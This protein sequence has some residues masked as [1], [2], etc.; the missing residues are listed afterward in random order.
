MASNNTKGYIARIG[1]NIDG[2][3]QALKTVT[4]SMS[5]FKGMLSSLKTS[6]N[7]DPTNIEVIGTQFARCSEMSDVFVQTLEVMKGNYADFVKQLDSEDPSGQMTKNFINDFNNL[8][9]LVERYKSISGE[10]RPLITEQGSQGVQEF[11]DAVEKQND[12]LSEQKSRLERLIPEYDR[13]RSAVVGISEQQAEAENKLSDAHT[14]SSAVMEEY[15]KSDNAKRD[16]LVSKRSELVSKRDS[17]GTNATDLE[18]INAEIFSIDEALS[19]LSINEELDE[20]FTAIT[21]EITNLTAEQER[22]QAMFTDANTALAEFVNTNGDIDEIRASIERVDNQMAVLAQ[23]ADSVETINAW[24]KL[25]QELSGMDEATEETRKELERVNAA[26]EFDP[27]NP[28]LLAQKMSLLGKSTEDANEKLKALVAEQ[29]NMRN[30]L[31]IGEISQEEYNAYEQALM[32]CRTEIRTLTSEQQEL[33]DNTESMGMTWKDVF[34]ANIVA[35]FVHDGLQLAIDKTKELAAEAIEVGKSFDTAMSNTAGTFAITKDSETYA[36][37]KVYAQEVGATTKYTATE[38]AEALNYYALAGYSA[39]E[40]I[41]SL[42]ATLK[43]AQAGAMDFAKSTD[44]LTDAF[45][46]LGGITTLEDMVDQMTVTSQKSN[47][48]VEQLGEA[49]LTIGATARNLKGGTAE[50][51]TMLGILADNGLKGEEGGTKLRNAITALVKPTAD[52]KAVLEEL[53]VSLYDTDGKMRA[54]PDVLLEFNNA[55]SGFTQQQR[56]EA[57]ATVFNSRDLGAVNALLSTTKER[58]TELQ[59]EIERSSGAADALVD[60]QTNNLESA[61]KMVTSAKEALQYAV[62]DK[63]ADGLQDIALNGADALGRVTEML[64]DADISAHIERLTDSVNG[65]I[66]K[67]LT[68]LESDGLEAIIDTMS[69]TVDVVNWLVTNIDTLATVAKSAGAAFA[70][71]KLKDIASG[72]VTLAK[73][74][75]NLAQATFAAETAQTGLN[76]AQK[77]NIYLLIAS[78]VAALGVAIADFVDRTAEAKVA[79]ADYKNELEETYLAINEQRRMYEEEKLALEDNLNAVDKSTSKIKDRWRVLQGMV[80]EDGNIVTA[81]EEV[82]KILLELNTLM[83]SNIQLINGQVQGYKD[84]AGSMDDYIENLR[85]TKKLEYM[86]DAYVEALGTVDAEQSTANDYAHTYTEKYLT[87]KNFRQEYEYAYSQ[88][89][90]SDAWKT[91]EEKYKNEIDYD[92]KD[93]AS[94]LFMISRGDLG[95]SKKSVGSESYADYLD[96]LAQ[97][98]QNNMVAQQNTVDRLKETMEE[99][100]SASV[101]LANKQNEINEAFYE[102]SGTTPTTDTDTTTTDT[103]SYTEKLD[104][105]MQE[106]DDKLAIHAMSEDKYWTARRAKLQ[107]LRNDTSKEWWAYQDEVSSYFENDAKTALSEFKNGVDSE[108]LSLENMRDELDDDTKDDVWY[109]KE[110]EKIVKRLEG[111]EIYDAYYKKLLDAQQ[112][113]RDSNNK[114][115]QQEIDDW[116]NRSEETQKAVQDAYKNVEEAYKQ[117]QQSYANSLTLAEKGYDAQGK[118]RYILTDLEKEKKRL[119]AYT[120]NLEKLKDTGISDDL[121]NEILSLNYDSGEREGVIKEI[122]TLSDKKRQEY[123]EDYAEYIESTKKAGAVQIEGDL[124]DANKAAVEGI[125]SIYEDMPSSAYEKGLETADAY[126]QGIT[127]GMVDVNSMFSAM[128]IDTAKRVIPTISDVSQGMESGVSASMPQGYISEDTPIVINVAGET[129]INQRLKEFFNLNTLTGGNNTGL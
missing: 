65:L 86:N 63:Y 89:M 91:F 120:K 66:D 31:S 68:R 64:Q 128:G 70:V 90:K 60:V 32:D 97:E 58:Y 121:Y 81:E 124:E 127:D 126:I 34:S 52:A 39:E 72:A 117:A 94:Y 43:L 13:L 71:W 26:L 75:S 10:V 40:A 87:A 28:V 123:Y 41:A 38:A 129:V 100:E 46:A 51:N 74:L 15:S 44:M 79:L 8:S 77:A 118:D 84:L 73:N 114:A 35:D 56:D 103:E 96:Y 3:D 17:E 82:A 42:P 2:F 23:T 122:L 119:D 116:G 45:T 24:G 125:I 80:D 85:T 49:V 95:K 59:S 27:E 12:M 9:R 36:K 76:A 5:N 53:N 108:I 16:E 105:A 4:T 47:T 69:G 113:V 33:S 54:L 111:T 107:E 55:M 104:A 48:N 67:T 102:A 115:V 7:L 21:E 57:V 93:Y 50:L 25:K 99:Y 14:R 78:A 1:V 110:L 83:G 11:T 19:N 37:L 29:D 101:E 92:N 98:A 30:A 22:L 109:A 20:Q 61:L 6:I 62:Y 88:G 112:K 18:S 106:L